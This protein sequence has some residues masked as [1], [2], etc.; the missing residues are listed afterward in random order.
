MF[1]LRFL[2]KIAGNVLRL[3]DGGAFEKRQPNVCTKD[4]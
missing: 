1:I 2:R 4:E 3:G